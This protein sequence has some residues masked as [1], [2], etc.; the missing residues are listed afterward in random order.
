MKL[1]HKIA[2]VTGSNSGIGRAIAETF[3]REGADV[4]VHYHDDVDGANATAESVRACGRRTAT[5]QADFSDPQQAGTFIERATQAL[6]SPDVLVNNAGI[7]SSHKHSLDMS[8]EE[9]RRILEV[10]LVVPWLLCQAA[11]QHMVVRGGGAIVNITS[12]HEEISLPGSAAYDAAKAALRSITRT[13]AL[14]LAPRGVRLNNVAPGLIATPLTAGTVNTPERMLKAAQQIP[15][16]RAGAPQE[17]ANV[18][19][20]L[21]SDEASYITGASYVVDGGLMRNIGGT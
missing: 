19:L 9:F 14:E 12:V 2:W 6:G 8:L 1:D 11:A 21:A 5:V 20:F 16:R 4:L 3:A 18:V 13:L 15:M 7:G 17:V 10:D